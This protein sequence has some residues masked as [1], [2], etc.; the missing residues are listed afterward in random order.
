MHF[1]SRTFKLT[2]ATKTKEERYFIQCRT[3]SYAQH[4][5]GSKPKPHQGHTF[6]WRS[7]LRN[8]VSL[9]R[10][11]QQHHR[12]MVR[13]K[14]TPRHA[15]VRPLKCVVFITRN[16]VT[17]AIHQHREFYLLDQQARETKLQA[18]Y[19][20]HVHTPPAWCTTTITTKDT[21]HH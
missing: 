18:E 15:E 8:F 11:K 17:F 5:K 3:R 12:H 19:K 4:T 20:R 7:S 2:G 16:P 21:T 14:S 10:E 1:T 9:E 6:T 13:I